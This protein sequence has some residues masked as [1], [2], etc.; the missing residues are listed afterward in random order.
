[1]PAMTGM[2]ASATAV[3]RSDGCSFLEANAASSSSYEPNSTSPP[4]L[5]GL[6]TR[7]FPPRNTICLHISRSGFASV[8]P[9]S[10]QALLIFERTCS[11]VSCTS[12]PE[13]GLDFDI[14]APLPAAPRPPS[15]GCC[16]RGWDRP[17]RRRWCSATGTFHPIFGNVSRT[18]MCILR[19]S[20][21]AWAMSTP[22][23][24][25]S[26]ACM[27]GYSSFARSVLESA[28][29]LPMMVRALR[30]RSSDMC[31]ANRT[32]SRQYSGM[33]SYRSEPYRMF[34]PGQTAANALR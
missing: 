16:R 2:S 23:N 27:A 19:W 15:C 5:S 4:N 11:A 34:A 21:P 33:P 32:S 29:D 8:M 22:K 6:S 28:S 1:M 26:T 30:V 31:P 3:L 14:L 17:G 12:M 13:A 25:I 7:M 18:S 24:L 20:I 9:S 10:H